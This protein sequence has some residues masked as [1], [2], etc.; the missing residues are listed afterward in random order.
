MGSNLPSRRMV[1]A[2]IAAL[3]GAAVTGLA[4]GQADMVLDGPRLEPA[5][6]PAEYLVILCHGY[7]SNGDDLISIA[8]DLRSYLPNAYFV[9]P[10]GPQR[11]AGFFGYRW[12]PV[13]LIGRSPDQMKHDVLGAIPIVNAFADTELAKL[14]LGPERLI[15]VGFSQGA[16]T[17]LNSGIRRE[18]PPAAVVAFAGGIVSTENLPRRAEAPPV[19]LIQGAEDRQGDP[20]RVAEALETLKDAGVPVQSHT[21]PGLGHS[22]DG[23]GIRLAGEFIRDATQATLTSD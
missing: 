3:S 11:V 15:L 8:P 10:N 12:F 18:V 17:V 16:M 7:G 19:M 9:S 6:G 13:S 23:R 2:G 4:R 5:A 21:L 22:I 20:A 1:L 14:N